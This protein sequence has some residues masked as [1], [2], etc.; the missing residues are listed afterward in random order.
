MCPNRVVSTLIAACF[1]ASTSCSDASTSTSPGGQAAPEAPAPLTTLDG[2]VHLMPTRANNILL[3]L[4][5]GEDVVL[6]GSAAAALAN[7]ENAD[8]E[9]R[10]QWSADIFVVSDFLVR[11]V[12]GAD[13]LDGV[14]MAVQVEDDG[15]VIGYAL[16][17]T[18]G[19]VVPL[20]NPPAELTSH[21]GER[22]WVAE[23]ADGQAGAFGIISR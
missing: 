23:T 3:T 10:G 1:V 5:D 6:D 4:A 12:D 19:S 7:V 22:V 15:A 17:L 8:V 18:R 14:L 16:N 21:V 9:V 11:Q 2:K 20:T 13:V